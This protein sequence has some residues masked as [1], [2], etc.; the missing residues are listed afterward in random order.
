MS[1]RVSSSFKKRETISKMPL[2]QLFHF[3]DIKFLKQPLNQPRWSSCFR[4]SEL[5][6]YIPLISETAEKVFGALGRE[7]MFMVVGRQ[8][9][10]SQGSLQKYYWQLA[11]LMMM[12]SDWSSVGL[13][14]IR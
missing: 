7:R 10:T 9:Y 3:S 5:S 6:I 2:N 13:A 12:P 11:A 4:V 8:D 14:C 1:C